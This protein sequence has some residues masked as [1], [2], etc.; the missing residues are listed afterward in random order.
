MVRKSTFEKAIAEE[1]SK[2]KERLEKRFGV[3]MILDVNW[4]ITEGPFQNDMNPMTI[5]G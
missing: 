4:Q 2:A 5:G 1:M 3:K